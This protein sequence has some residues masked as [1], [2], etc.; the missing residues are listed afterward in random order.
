M[1]PENAN[2]AIIEDSHV[3]QEA[4]SYSLRD[5]GHKIVIRAYTYDQAIEA[6]DKFKEKG[7]QVV[8]L[9]G[10]LGKH[11]NGGQL[12]LDEIRRRKLPVSVIDF[13]AAG[14]II[15]VDYRLGKS[16]HNLPVLAQVITDLPYK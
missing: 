16:G 3:L 13:S 15:G 6:L 12:I 9:D 8:L 5:T 4:F 2:L 1:C 7:V 10:R 14:D 11:D